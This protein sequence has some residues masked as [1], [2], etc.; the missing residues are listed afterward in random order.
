MSEAPHK[1]YRAYMQDTKT[2]RIFK[3]PH[4]C[5][6]REKTLDYAKRG[7]GARYRV[8]YLVSWKLKYSLTVQPT[9]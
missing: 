5:R 1:L 7:H 3:G 2:G 6:S 9:A 8:A 4:I